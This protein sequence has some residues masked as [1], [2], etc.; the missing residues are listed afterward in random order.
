MRKFTGPAAALLLVVSAQSSSGQAPEPPAPRAPVSPS[1]TT[2]FGDAVHGRAID[3]VAAAAAVAPQGQA[4][5]ENL[6]SVPE[7]SSVALLAS[8]TIGLG[9]ALWRRRRVRGR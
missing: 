7:P 6:T 5:A 3:T 9:A 2:V 8:G 4:R 1:A